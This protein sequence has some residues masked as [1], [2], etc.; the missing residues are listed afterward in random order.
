M[1]RHL[2]PAQRIENRGPREVLGGAI[3]ASVG[4]NHDRSGALFGQRGERHQRGPEDRNAWREVIGRRAEDPTD[5]GG[6]FAEAQDTKARL[7]CR[8]LNLCDR[9]GERLATR[10]AIAREV[11]A[12]RA[13]GEHEYPRAYEAPARQHSGR[14]QNR[15]RRER[16][17]N[18][19]R[20]SDQ[21]SPAPSSAKLDDQ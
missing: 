14:A 13:I 19:T 5:D 8:A 7:P 15:E 11:E 20:K 16:R 12:A 18:E 2:E 4:E 6:P 9:A 17:R 3:E 1:N 21:H 10:P